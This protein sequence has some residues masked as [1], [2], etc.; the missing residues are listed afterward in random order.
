MPFASS[1]RRAVPVSIVVLFAF[2]LA[3]AFSGCKD[4]KKITVPPPP[5]EYLEQSSPANVLANLQTAYQRK[6]CGEYSKLFAPDFVFLFNP[7]DVNDP[8]NPTPPDW[9][10]PAETASACSLFAHPRVETITLSWSV[11]ALEADTTYGWKIRVDEVN[12]NV[13]A[14]N[15]QNELWIYQVRGSHQMFYFREED[16]T[17]PSGKKKWT[18]IRWEDS[19][20]G[21]GKTQETSWGQ[22]KHNFR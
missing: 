12:L 14:R 7:S 6:N 16:V 20:I 2:L 5:S 19:P 4:D 1:A 10:F 18:C 22:I 13:N 8:T 3:A 21:S 11:G 15:E 9:G 17:L